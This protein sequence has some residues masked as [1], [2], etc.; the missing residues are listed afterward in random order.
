MT[1]DTDHTQ[2]CLDGELHEQARYAIRRAD[3]LVEWAEA[4]TDY[5]NA[6]ARVLAASTKYKEAAERC[7]LMEERIAYLKLQL[8]ERD[9]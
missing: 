5:N 8:A 6:L 7:E 3:A 9:S 1:T 2:K 4:L